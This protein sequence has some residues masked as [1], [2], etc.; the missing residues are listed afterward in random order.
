MEDPECKADEAGCEAKKKGAAEKVEELEKEKDAIHA[1]LKKLDNDLVKIVEKIPE[2][3]K[4][5]RL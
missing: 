1:D 4:S 3:C 5:M 2:K